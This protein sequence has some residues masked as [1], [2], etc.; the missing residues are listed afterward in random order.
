M[1]IP[2]DKRRFRANIYLNLASD[3]G[4][5]EDELVGRKL[6]IG[7]SAEI[8]VLE[9]DPRCKMISLDP[10]TGEH[11]PEVLRKVAQAHGYLCR[12]LLRGFGGRN[13][14]ERRFNRTVG[15]RAATAVKILLTLIDNY[16]RDISQFLLDSKSTPDIKFARLEKH[17]Q[18]FRAAFL[19]SMLGLAT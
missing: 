19:V 13:V 11:N 6:R 17:D 5:A 16:K 7:S 15:L 3:S 1:G 8:M 9:R 14:D 12:R 18:S 4:F 10:D 2:V